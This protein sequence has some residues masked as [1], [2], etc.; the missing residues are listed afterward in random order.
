MWP[1]KQ[2]WAVFCLHGIEAA[3]AKLDQLIQQC[4]CCQSASQP[5]SHAAANAAATSELAS[6][7]S[8]Q[9][10]AAALRNDITGLPEG[11]WAVLSYS[12]SSIFALPGYSS[13]AEVAASFGLQELTVAVIQ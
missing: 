5:V 2:R 13:F 7:P 9:Q 3:L 12:V 4:K 6:A 10:D 8:A 11:M 1:R